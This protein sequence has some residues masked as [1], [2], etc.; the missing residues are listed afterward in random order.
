MASSSII[1]ISV[2]ICCLVIIS[3]V[4]GGYFYYKLEDTDQNI[5]MTQQIPSDPI[6]L[7]QQTSSD[8]ITTNK[9]SVT[10][11]ILISSTTSNTNTNTNTT[12]KPSAWKSYCTKYCASKDIKSSS[13]G[14]CVS[15]CT[16]T[17]CPD[18]DYT[19]PYEKIPTTTTTKTTTTKPSA[20]K[21]YCTTYCSSKDVKSY[22]YGTCVSKCTPVNCADCDYT[23]PYTSS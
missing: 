16:P 4:A 20:W 10:S 14:T 23:G 15:N 19:G 3:L 9:P 18:C 17:K 11:N 1:I 22:T 2:S 6:N 12:T 13:Y 8:V 7:A 5:Q 21:S